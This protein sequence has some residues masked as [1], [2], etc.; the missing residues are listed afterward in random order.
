[1]T[2]NSLADL[3]AAIEERRK[4]CPSER[5][6]QLAF[7]VLYQHRPDLSEMVRATPADPFYSE[8]THDPRYVK[9]MEIITPRLVP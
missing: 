7:N 2:I 6:G 4:E 3:Q 5:E 1:M 8:S 9:F